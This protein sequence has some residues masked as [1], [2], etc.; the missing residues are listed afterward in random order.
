MIKTSIDMSFIAKVSLLFFL[1]FGLIE[2]KHLKCEPVICPICDFRLTDTY[3]DVVQR[4]LSNSTYPPNGSCLDT[5]VKYLF[6]GK[7]YGFNHDACCC[8]PIL[9]T[10]PVQCN[11]R[12]P[13]VPE[14]ANNLGSRKGENVADYNKRVGRVQS[15]APSNGC[16]RN[17][18]FKY[19]YAKELTGAPNDIC[20][21][22]IFNVAYAIDESSSS[23]SENH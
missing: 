16:C 18:T 3:D 10:S 14:C 19:I 22:I 11:P 12:D 20:T 8:I 21:C 6:F 23:S 13:S 2:A 15:N 1:A 4:T 5:T 9:P 7:D 17:G